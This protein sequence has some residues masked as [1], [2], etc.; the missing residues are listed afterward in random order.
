MAVIAS[1]TLVIDINGE[2]FYTNQFSIFSD[3]AGH[4]GIDSNTSNPSY[5]FLDALSTNNVGSVIDE[6]DTGVKSLIANKLAIQIYL[7]SS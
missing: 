2:N 5:L 3:L 6:V 1:V 4:Y 7:K